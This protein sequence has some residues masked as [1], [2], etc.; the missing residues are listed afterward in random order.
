MILYVLSVHNDASSYEYPAIQ[1]AALLELP[2]GPW[3]PLLRAFYG[4]K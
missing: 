2:D 3:Y 4:G 1:E